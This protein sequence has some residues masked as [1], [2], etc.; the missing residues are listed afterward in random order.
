MNNF[1]DIDRLFGTPLIQIPVNSNVGLKSWQIVTGLVVVGFA[2]YGMFHLVMKARPKKL[3]EN[4]SKQ[5]DTK[6]K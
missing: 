4:Y 3:E 5:A 1:V 6:T 2:A